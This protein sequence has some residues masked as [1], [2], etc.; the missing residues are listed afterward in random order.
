VER[1][2]AWGI[3]ECVLLLSVGS[4]AAGQ[5]G[6][7][8]RLAL[9]RAGVVLQLPE[10]WDCSEGPATRAGEPKLAT[11]RWQPAEGAEWEFLCIVRMKDIPVQRPKLRKVAAALR[12]ALPEEFQDVRILRE[13]ARRIGGMGGYHLDA[14]LTMN[15]QPMHA[16]HRWFAV[17]NRVVQFSLLSPAADAARATRQFDALMGAIRP[18]ELP[19]GVRA[20]ETVLRHSVEAAARW[21]KRVTAGQ[22][23][24]LAGPP[25]YFFIRQGELVL[26]ATGYHCKPQA[27]GKGFR[28]T[29]HLW[30]ENLQGV[31]FTQSLTMTA[32][33]GGAEE[34]FR[35]RRRFLA[36]GKPTG[37]QESVDAVVRDLRL[38]AERRMGAVTDYLQVDL[39]AS[40]VPQTTAGLYRRHLARAARGAVMLTELDFAGFRLQ[41]SLFVPRGRVP[42]IHEGR[43]RAAIQTLLLKMVDGAVITTWYD[44]ASGEPLRQKLDALT[45]TPTTL[46]EVRKRFPDFGK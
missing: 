41:D 34:A 31:G 14:S 6:G 43:P 35:F 38:S 5:D 3:L 39:P 11:L 21:K 8:R 32:T 37:D 40:Y 36:R 24:A 12:K 9:V 23:A 18:L 28:T 27:E 30:F 46:T 19:E 20:S 4:P 13:G 10:G 16:L 17:D 44:P 29:S 33:A 25:S 26:G 7:A 1:G 22:L 45:L 2:Y 15:G 42:I